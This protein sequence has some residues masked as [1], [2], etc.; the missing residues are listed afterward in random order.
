MIDACMSLR[1][2]KLTSASRSRSLS[3]SGEDVLSRLSENLD[4]LGSFGS[5]VGFW[6]E[7]GSGKRGSGNGKREAGAGSGKREAEKKPELVCLH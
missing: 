4:A 7:A 6:R 3:T 1:A 2:R 5:A